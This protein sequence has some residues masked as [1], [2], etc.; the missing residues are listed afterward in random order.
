MTP[1]VPIPHLMEDMTPL[2]VFSY[3]ILLLNMY[4]EVYLTFH[5]QSCHNILG[6]F[7]ISP[8]FP[9]TANETKCDYK[10]CALYSRNALFHMK[11]GVRLKYFSCNLVTESVT[12]NTKLINIK[13]S[14]NDFAKF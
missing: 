3:I 8:N 5:P 9:F 11:T 7:D 12:V 4:R 2:S 1:T 14:F 10:L 13:K 6:M